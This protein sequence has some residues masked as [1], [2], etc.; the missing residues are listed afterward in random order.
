VGNDELKQKEKEIQNKKF[1]A[2]LVII[3]SLG[4]NIT[5]TQVLGW[6]KQFF[7]FEFHDGWVG[8]G[9]FTSA[10]ISC[11]NAYPVKK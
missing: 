4:D 2:K 9:G 11:Y 7:N 8:A 6:P 10:A 1:A 3:K 5:A